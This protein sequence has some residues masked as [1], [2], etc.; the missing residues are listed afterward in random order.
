M[1]DRKRKRVE[2]SVQNN[3]VD[4]N[5]GKLIGEDDASSKKPMCTVFE[6]Y[7]TQ[8]YRAGY[9][10]GYIEKFKTL[11]P[12]LNPAPQPVPVRQSSTR[13]Q[14]TQG[15]QGLHDAD[16]NHGKVIGANAARKN[17]KKRTV[18]KP[19][20]TTSYINGYNAGYDSI[21]ARLTSEEREHNAGW[22]RGYDD[23]KRGAPMLTDFAP[24]QK[25]D[26]I[27]GYN[28]GYKYVAASFEDPQELD[29]NRG[30][31]CGYD[32]GYKGLVKRTKFTNESE[33]F[34]CG[35]EEGFKLGSKNRMRKKPR[36]EANDE[37]TYALMMRLLPV[38]AEL[39]MKID[40]SLNIGGV[41]HIPIEAGEELAKI[42]PIVRQEMGISKLRK[43]SSR[44]HYNIAVDIVKYK[45]WLTEHQPK[46]AK[47]ADV[48]THVE[49]SSLSIPTTVTPS[50][51]S[52]DP[53]IILP[54]SYLNN[55]ESMSYE[56]AQLFDEYQ[57][58][59]ANEV[60]DELQ[61]QKKNETPADLFD[62]FY[63]DLGDDDAVLSDLYVDNR[64][65]SNLNISSTLFYHATNS[66]SE[67][68]LNMTD[69]LNN[70]LI[71]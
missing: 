28:E 57:M 5:Y 47:E 32:A 9:R 34:I 54:I 59:M 11:L 30:K 22:A 45:A 55:D 7:R 26:Y 4:F 58:D 62:W 69:T 46:T 19:G 60:L 33:V 31:A 49:A 21:I 67:D 12:T 38:N 6:D 41:F 37:S 66:E 15:I 68:E 71:S 24:E 25:K 8:A 63:S 29:R 65:S 1:Q 36:V 23:A 61:A 18:F 13:T 14:H 53:L 43:I 51:Q 52:N 56:P 39:E 42:K 10:E 2:S 40:M 48:S 17:L 20:T 44:K 35:Y 64:S 27:N 70:F 3:F 16:Y 50:L